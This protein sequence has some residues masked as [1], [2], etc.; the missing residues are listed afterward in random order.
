[1]ARDAD[2]D[3][4][5]RVGYTYSQRRVNYDEDAFL[6][7][8]PMANAIP[9]NQ[10]T[11]VYGYLQQTGL[12]GF[13]PIAGYP[14][15]PL[16]GSAAVYSPNNNIVPQSFYASN[17]NI[18]KLVGMRRYNMADRNRDRL[19][20]SLDWAP[21]DRTTLQ[22]V[23]DYDQDDYSN[24]VFGLQNAKKWS[25][26]FD[27]GYVVN[28]NLSLDAFYTYEDQRSTSAGDSYGANSSQAFI[29]QQSNTLV[30]GGCY[31]TVQAQSNNGKLD[32]CLNWSTD[33]RDKVNT[34]GLNAKLK[35][36][37]ASHLDLAGGILYSRARTDT[38]VNGGAYVNN[39]LATGGGPALAAGVPALFFINATPYPTVTTNMFELRLAGKYT[40]DK[41]QA[42]RV[43][44]QFQHLQSSDY[45]YDGM[46]YGTLT[47]VMPTN[48][49]APN[50]NV[51]VFG[52]SYVRTFR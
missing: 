46:Q 42:V 43:S 33:M 23:F 25:V 3:L 41:E 35:G 27:G 51:H 19:R 48:K 34:V 28:E 22:A 15:T 13:G 10:T 18:N 6:A 30:A 8:V 44:Y 12:T 39:P 1:M 36:L 9:N 29:A 21:N 7:L 17:N 2:Q 5:G 20:S 24:S 14:A 11:S 50:Y 32:P 49:T 4:S 52:I 37:L 40:I 26:D 16:T 47:N 45:A 31:S 38:G